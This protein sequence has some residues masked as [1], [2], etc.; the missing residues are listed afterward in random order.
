MLPQPKVEMGSYLAAGQKVS[1]KIKPVYPDTGSSLRP[2]KFEIKYKIGD[3]RWVEQ[4]IHNQIG[5]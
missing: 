2:T 3:G 1:V 5:G 4:T